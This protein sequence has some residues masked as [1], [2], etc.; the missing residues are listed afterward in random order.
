M[1]SL[2]VSLE[3][4]SLEFALFN[5]FSQSSSSASHTHAE[6]QFN[7][8]LKHFQ[9]FRLHF[10]ALHLQTISS[11]ISSG[12]AD[13]F[14]KTGAR[15]THSLLSFHPFPIGEGSCGLGIIADLHIAH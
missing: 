15:L 12:A 13:C 7:P 11:R 6:V 8:F 3:S 10:E 14:V 9:L 2:S 1:S 5:S 4:V